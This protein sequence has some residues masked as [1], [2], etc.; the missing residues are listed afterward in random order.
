LPEDAWFVCLHVREPGFH[1]SW[2]KQ[3]PGTRHA[4][5]ATYDKAIDFVTKAGG[6]VVRLGDH[7]MSPIP[8]RPQ[9]IDY[10][11]SSFRNFDLDVLLCALCSYFI[12]TNSGLSLVPPLFGRRSVLTNWSPIAI[13]NWYLDDLYIPKLVR[14]VAGKRY[15]SFSEMFHSQ[16]GWTQWQRDYKP[17]IEQL[18]DNSPDDIL[19]AVMDLHEEIFEGRV[20]TIAEQAAVDR[21]NKVAVSGGGYVGS[22]IGRRFLAKYA[23]LLDG[24]QKASDETVV[25]VSPDLQTAAVT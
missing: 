11:N 2:H 8:A 17:G 7:S 13:P 4:D 21:F 19:D 20:L 1:A 3:H 5:I 12:G 9:V 6:W 23:H 10:A 22:R 15:L 16:A 25:R 18:E 14:K 24:K